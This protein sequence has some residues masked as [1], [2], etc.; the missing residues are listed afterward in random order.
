MNPLQEQAEK[1]LAYLKQ[2][3]KDSDMSELNATILRVAQSNLNTVIA[4][5]TI[6]EKQIK[7]K[8]RIY[9]MIDILTK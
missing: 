8:N 6:L 3:L 5:N 1:D 4:Y 2:S 9:S 7:L